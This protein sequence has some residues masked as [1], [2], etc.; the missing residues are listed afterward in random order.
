[1]ITST[2]HVLGHLSHI[3][4]HLVRIT[5]DLG[6]HC[7]RGHGLRK[8]INSSSSH[9][10]SM[11]TVLQRSQRW[12]VSVPNTPRVVPLGSA[13]P[14]LSLARAHKRHR[15]SSHSQCLTSKQ[16]PGRTDNAIKNRWHATLRRLIRRERNIASGKLN[17]DGTPARG[18]NPRPYD[19]FQA[20]VARPQ[21]PGA[22]GGAGGPGVFYIP[23]GHSGPLL[24]NAF[25]PNSAAAALTQYLQAPQS[26]HPVPPPP[27]P[28]QPPP[29]A[30]S[31]DAEA[32]AAVASLAAITS[33][34]VLE[35]LPVTRGYRRGGCYKGG[36]HGTFPAAPTAPCS[37]Q[38][39]LLP[40][41]VLSSAASCAG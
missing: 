6:S 32:A 17:P 16:V 14:Y 22:A 20:L 35:C 25:P 26:K 24:H 10:R 3:M 18:K 39:P 31:V 4:G 21:L 2:Y 27:P 29:G 1:M 28:M 7:C 37:L 30:V 11:A 15:S 34:G 19:P 8:K 38:P 33:A 23:P 9:R 5:R 36:G 40:A 41:R 13:G 12:Y